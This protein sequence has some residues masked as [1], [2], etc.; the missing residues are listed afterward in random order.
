MNPTGEV[1]DIVSYSERAHKVGATVLVD[2]T[3]APPPLSWPIEYGIYALQTF[4]LEIGFTS[5]I[6]RNLLYYQVPILFCTPQQNIFQVIQTV[7]AASS[8]LNQRKKLARLVMIDFSLGQFLVHLKP[9][10]FYDH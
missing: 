4:V 1:H 7:W 8:L 2:S 5:L 10:C 6:L 3:F 9:G